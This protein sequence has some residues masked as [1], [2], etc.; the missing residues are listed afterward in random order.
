MA[1]NRLLSPDKL[2]TSFRRALEAE[3]LAF[4]ADFKK[5]VPPPDYF[6][7]AG[8]VGAF[9]EIGGLE[10]LPGS[11]MSVVEVLAYFGISDPQAAELLVGQEPVG[12]RP[13]VTVK[14]K[15]E[16]FE[17]V[18]YGGARNPA[19]KTVGELGSMAIDRNRP[20]DAQ[21]AATYQTAYGKLSPHLGKPVRQIRQEM[22]LEDS[23]NLAVVPEDCVAS[24]VSAI[25]VKLLMN[26]IVEDQPNA[27]AIPVGA[28]SLQ[29][30]VLLAEFADVKRTPIRLETG[31]IVGGLSRGDPKT[32]EHANYLETT[33]EV[34]GEVDYG[35]A[36]GDVGDNGKRH[37][38]AALEVEPPA[39][40]RYRIDHPD[41]QQLHLDHGALI[42]RTRSEK[43]NTMVLP[44]LRGGYMAQGMREYFLD[45]SGNEKDEVVVGVRA[46]RVTGVDRNSRPHF[47]VILNNPG[48]DL[49]TVLR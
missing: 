24:V 11:R 14:S 7:V 3:D 2:A 15:D 21:E 38:F 39:F 12:D 6:N 18:I 22:G 8:P 40:D 47:G 36:V 33:P 13:L 26:Y 4:V 27:L 31:R 1:E 45:Q 5:K 46:S 43:S 20:L 42:T 35:L 41:L 37:A 32:W 17:G 29:A 19:A 49:R 16:Y 23:I 25:T 10:L 28:S 30:L 44:L 9:A 48:L 34:D